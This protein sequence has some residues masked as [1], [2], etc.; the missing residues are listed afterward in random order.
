MHAHSDPKTFEDVDESLP[1]V[2]KRHS[3]EMKARQT[4]KIR[5]IGDA[6]CAAGYLS[7][8]EQAV[9]LGLCRSTTWTVLQAS[10]KS[11]GLTAALVNRM[12]VAPGLPPA[13]RAQ[14]LQYV[15]EKAAGLYGH[16]DTRRRKFVAAL[17]GRV[18]PAPK[19]TRRLRA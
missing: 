2:S 13:V 17:S 5:E 9:A 18:R 16:C 10:H 6:L 15:E 1:S 19:K 3:R 12:L 8:D 14:I 7:L 4:A 11:S